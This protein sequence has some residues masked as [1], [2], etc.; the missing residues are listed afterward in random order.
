MSLRDVERTMQVMVWFYKHVDTLGRLMEEVIT[1]QRREEGEDVDDDDDADE[2]VIMHYL[3]YLKRSC[4]VAATL[5]L[6]VL[7]LYR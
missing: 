6:V 1:K 7:I 3:F 4:R 5:D 2:E